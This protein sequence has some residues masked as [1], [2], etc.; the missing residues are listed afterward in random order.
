VQADET[1][2]HDP[3]A[4]AAVAVELAQRGRRRRRKLISMK[5]AL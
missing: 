2:R 5:A 1:I 3:G 4:I